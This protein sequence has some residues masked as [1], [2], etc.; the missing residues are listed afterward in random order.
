MSRVN[1]W[2]P[3]V[4]LARLR[5]TLP[6]VSMSELVQAAVTGVLSCAH[7]SAV[8]CAQ[9]GAHVEIEAIR[10]EARAEMW[11]TIESRVRLLVGT[12][13]TIVGAHKVIRDEGVRAGVVAAAR[14]PEARR[15]RAHHNQGD[16]IGVGG[17]GRVER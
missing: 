1:V 10:A 12:H 7:T 4:L 16:A 6:G 11:R 3:D 2:V 5:E 17:M 13:G 9:C 15:S 8:A 14:T